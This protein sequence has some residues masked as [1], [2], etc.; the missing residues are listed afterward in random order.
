MFRP[1]G[2]TTFGVL[3]REKEGKRPGTSKA[4]RANDPLKRPSCAL[5]AAFGMSILRSADRALLSSLLSVRCLPYTQNINLDQVLRTPENA[6][7]IFSFA[8]FPLR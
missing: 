7:N 6:L 1:V 8:A 4:W 2:L 5:V 3:Q